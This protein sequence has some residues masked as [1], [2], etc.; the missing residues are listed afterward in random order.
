VVT[1]FGERMLE[2]ARRLQEDWHAA[3]A[4]AQHEQVTEVRHQMR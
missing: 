1:D 2:Y 3:M 4:L